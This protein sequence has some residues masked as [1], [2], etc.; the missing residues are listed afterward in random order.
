MTDSTAGTEARQTPVHRPARRR[1]APP[2]R[3]LWSRIT[4][5]RAAYVFILP[6]IIL[7]ALF[8]VV[9]LVHSIVMSF[10]NWN[11]I[12]APEY[13]G[14][15]NYERLFSERRFG[16]AI[17]NNLIF[18]V[19]FTSCTLVLGFLSAVAISRR[20]RFW[21]FYRFAFF[22]PYVLVTAVIAVLWGQIY[23]PS[24]GILNTALRAVGLDSLTQLW[25]G[26]H[27]ITMYSIVAIAI[28]QISGFTMLLYLAA[29]EGIDQEIHDAATIDGVN[30]WQRCIY[31]IAPMVKQIT[32]VLIMLQIIASLKTFDLIW[33]LTKGGPFYASEV[34]GTYLYRAAFEQQQFGY[35]S[36]VALVMTVIVM[37]VT[38]VYLALTNLPNKK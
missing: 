31:I 33:V 29:M 30:A 25:L 38:I 17:Q 11:G 26:N 27:R 2:V 19:L 21:R 5:Y 37:A 12:T 24:H 1:S 15:A 9:P 32:F 18:L 16:Q 13:I 8:M 6:S 20:M 7:L 35:A 28:W 23:E 22:V 34:M 3:S 36:A 14:M 4:E 10:H